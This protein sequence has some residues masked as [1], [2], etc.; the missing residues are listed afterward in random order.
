MR[1]PGT[2]ALVQEFENLLLHKAEARDISSHEH[3]PIILF[4]VIDAMGT[5]T[6]TV[7]SSYSPTPMKGLERAQKQ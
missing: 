2:R 1:D 6:M 5:K 3:Q 7:S 4:Y